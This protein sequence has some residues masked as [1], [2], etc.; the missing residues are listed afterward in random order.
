MRNLDLFNKE[1]NRRRIFINTILKP[2]IF[3]ERDRHILNIMESGREEAVIRNFWGAMTTALM[4]LQIEKV[5][6]F[7]DWLG[8]NSQ[9]HWIHDYF[10]FTS[11][12][13]LPKI[14]TFTENESLQYFIVLSLAEFT[15]GQLKRPLDFDILSTTES[16]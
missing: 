10:Y 5:G 9:K 12:D 1:E 6:K 15:L 11:N 3:K 14:K 16:I 2:L 8:I 4:A 7:S 13:L